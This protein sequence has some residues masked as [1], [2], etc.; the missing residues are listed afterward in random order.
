MK[1][2]TLLC[3]LNT[4]SVFAIHAINLVR[5]F[6]KLGVYT[7]IRATSGLDK[8]TPD[9]IRARVVNGPQPE[10]WEIILHAPNLVPTNGKRT[11]YFSFAESEKLPEMAAHVLNKASC[12][13]TPSELSAEIFG[14]H[15][16]TVP[17]KTVPLELHDHAERLLKII[18][19]LSTPKA[20]KAVKGQKFDDTDAIV[21]FYRECKPAKRP[22]LEYVPGC[23]TN[24]VLGLGDT[25]MLTDLPKSASEAK[26]PYTCFSP[27]PHLKQLMAF[28]HFYR[29]PSLMDQRI[30][31][32]APSIV[33]LHD[34]GNG[35]YLQRLQRAFALPV[36]DKPMGFLECG[37]RQTG[38][39]FLHFEAGPHVEWQRKHIHP[40]ARLLSRES[41]ILLEEFIRENPKLRFNQV[42]FHDAKIKG[43]KYVRTEWTADLV[44]AIAQGEYFIG[45]MSGP[46]HIATA[47]GLKCVVV[48]NFP[49]AEKIF[50]PTLR[51]I[52]QVEES[53]F[54]PQNVHLHQEGE[55]PQV[56]RFTCENLHRAFNGELYPYWSD[57][58]L[59][60]IHEKL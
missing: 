19:T 28:N 22:R 3:D 33:H 4:T 25:M 43:A 50:L 5:E 39:V 49:P 21:R 44:R 51:A 24:L 31:G 34:V 41:K 9:D 10:E 27:S 52:D 12:V 40:K 59:P 55:G 57:K 32:N 17:I 6:D 2:F 26:K 23:L 36:K 46:L 45:I 29:P 58:F 30:M 38:V 35:H 47:L 53:W 13:V 18:E 37:T 48:V 7:S 20:T 56:K 42:G 60:L 16:V 11:L 14:L 15:G 54:Y 8:A 1:R